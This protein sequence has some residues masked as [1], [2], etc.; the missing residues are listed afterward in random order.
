VLKGIDI[1]NCNCG[2]RILSVPRVP[3][4]NALI[5]ENRIRKDSPLAGTE[6][7]FLR[8]NMGFTKKRLSEIMGVDNAT[9]SRWARDFQK[10]AKAHAHF[11]RLL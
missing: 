3:E 9:I 6:I 5:G 10:P 4:L 2:E 8:K 1:F 11:I 7:R